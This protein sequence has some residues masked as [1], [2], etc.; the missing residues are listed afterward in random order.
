M[1]NIFYEPNVRKPAEKLKDVFYVTTEP[2]QGA[3]EQL[4]QL[5]LK[6]IK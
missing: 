5:Y 1:L 6:K 2:F 4:A 3:E